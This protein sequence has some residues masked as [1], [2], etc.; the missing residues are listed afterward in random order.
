MHFYTMVR[1]VANEELDRKSIAEYQRA[2]KLPLVVVLDNIRSMNNVGSVFRSSDAFCI[3]R[4]ILTG[5]TARPPHREIQKTA[6]GATE[7]VEWTYVKEVTEAVKQLQEEEFEIIAVE[8][9]EPVTSL[10][11]LN[12][13]PQKKYALIFGNEVF[14]VGDEVVKMADR[15]VEIPQYGT[16]HSLNVAVSA[17]S[18][19]W[20]FSRNMNK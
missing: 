19:L 10:D 9:T 17:G 15:C 6:L 18:V 4:I 1:K 8:Q 20:E 16:K 3:S 13:D 12:V 7:S 11:N 14:G 2:P 5:I